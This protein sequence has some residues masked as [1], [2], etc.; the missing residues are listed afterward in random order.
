M[1]DIEDAQKAIN[2]ILADLEKKTGAIVERLSIY[3]V[4]ITTY[5]SDGRQMM[6][7]SLITMKDIPGSHWVIC[8]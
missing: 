2:L 3:D 4:D 7:S 6:R 1:S 5:E 8:P